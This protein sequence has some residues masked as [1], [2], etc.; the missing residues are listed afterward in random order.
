MDVALHPDIEPLACLLGTWVGEGAGSYPT[1]ED[2]RYREEVTF[3]HVGKPSLAY[4]QA[5]VLVATGLPSHAEAGYIRRSPAGAVELVL[6]HPTGVVEVAEGE[7]TPTADGLVLHLRSTSVVCAPTAKD[8]RSL[9][10][11]ITVAGD[12]LRYELAMGA[13]GQPH[14]HHLAAELHRRVAG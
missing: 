8:V 1:V 10:R 13:V 6:A 9:E 4:R 2:F 14:Q 12:V 3:G 5:T 11:H 7:A